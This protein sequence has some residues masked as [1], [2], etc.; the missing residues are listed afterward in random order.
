MRAAALLACLPLAACDDG[1]ITPECFEGAPMAIVVV[2]DPDLS[3]PPEPTFDCSPGIDTEFCGGGA[4]V[5]AE[6]EDL[7]AIRVVL[8]GFVGWWPWIGID[9]ET[10]RARLCANYY[11]DAGDGSRCDPPMCATGGTIRVSAMPSAD[12]EVSGV[13]VELDVVFDGGGTL[14]GSFWIP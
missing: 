1:G 11:S 8:M 9:P 14:A 3:P 4:D 2:V 10:R 7:I 6:V 12:A 13:A 5:S